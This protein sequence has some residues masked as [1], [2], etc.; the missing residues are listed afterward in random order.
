[1]SIQHACV[2]VCVCPSLHS[3]NMHYLTF[4]WLISWVLR[5]CVFKDLQSLESSKSQEVPIF[6]VI[7]LK[8]GH[9]PMEQSYWWEQLI[10]LWQVTKD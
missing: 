6:A 3:N 9:S 5:G 2:Y 1:M 4:N 8:W 10:W 7:S